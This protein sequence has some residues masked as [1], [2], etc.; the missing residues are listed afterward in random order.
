MGEA[1][2]GAPAI[3]EPLHQHLFNRSAS[4]LSDG[5][6]RFDGG[7][8][9]PKP[10]ANCFSKCSVIHERLIFSH[11]RQFGRKVAPIWWI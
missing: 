7:I 2:N 6:G 9:Q 5:D 8:Q 3:G 4:I 1:A 11:S 10:I